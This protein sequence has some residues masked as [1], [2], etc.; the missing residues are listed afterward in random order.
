ML[1]QISARTPIGVVYRLAIPL[2]PF[3][4]S[5]AVIEA[6]EGPTQS[7]PN[8]VAHA[9]KT[10]NPVN[11]I[12]AIGSQPTRDRFPNPALDGELYL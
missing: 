9:E 7:F 1:K 12:P 5:T 8:T 6:T 10:N 2:T 3:G 11:R 4:I